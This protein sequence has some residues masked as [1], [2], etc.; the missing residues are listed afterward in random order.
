MQQGDIIFVGDEVTAQGFRLS[1][2][3]V[4]SPEPGSE[5]ESF[6]DACRSG[7]LILLDSVC[8]RRLPRDQLDDALAAT[9]PLV[10]VVP[11]I[12][13][14]DAPGPADRVRRILGF[15]T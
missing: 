1:G 15:E 5:L 9:S 13:S 3:R 6:R 12:S 11:R 10:L 14:V 7:S 4:C 2:A 8:A